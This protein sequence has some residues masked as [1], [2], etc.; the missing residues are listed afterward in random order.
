MRRLAL[1]ISLA[2][3]GGGREAPKGLG[4]RA[5]P[6]ALVKTLEAVAALDDAHVGAALS[7]GTD[8]QTGRRTPHPRMGIRVFRSP[9]TPNGPSTKGLS[10]AASGEGTGSL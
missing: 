7:K 4:E 10:A 2:A 9:V 5:D 8:R 6:A 1:L 3:C